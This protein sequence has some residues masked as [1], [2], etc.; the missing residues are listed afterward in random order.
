MFSVADTLDAITSDRPYRPA[1]TFAAA[2]DE[3]TNL[4]GTQFDP[5]VVEV[6]VAMPDSL[7]ADLRREISSQNFRFAYP[8]RTA[9]A[10]V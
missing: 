3:I 7:W 10:T 4:A 2:R 6:F 8:Q 5:E 9:N 1:Q